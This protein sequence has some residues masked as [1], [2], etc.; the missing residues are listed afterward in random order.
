MAAQQLPPWWDVGHTNPRHISNFK[1]MSSIESSLPRR[2]DNKNPGEVGAVQEQ[3]DQSTWS[4]T[5]YW[6]LLATS[7]FG[8]AVV[9]NSGTPSN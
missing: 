2:D 6:L 4:R 5:D 7:V 3:R 1:H 9:D 8:V